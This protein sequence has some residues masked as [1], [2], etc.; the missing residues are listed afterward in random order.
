[1]DG[2]G[3]GSKWISEWNAIRY[4]VVGWIKETIPTHPSPSSHQNAIQYVFI[5]FIFVYVLFNCILTP[6]I[7]IHSHTFSYTKPIH[8]Q[9]HKWERAQGRNIPTSHVFV[10]LVWSSWLSGWRSFPQVLTN[11]T[12]VRTYW[13]ALTSPALQPHL[14]LPV[15]FPLL[16]QVSRGQA[17]I[18]PAYDNTRG[19]ILHKELFENCVS[20]RLSFLGD[21]LCH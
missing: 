17:S 8:T 1:M 5:F 2:R 15:Y 7:L 12:L 20:V 16:N 14:L 11:D 6:S 19:K 13:L 9:N 18:Q 21:Y 10:C 3:R 4:G